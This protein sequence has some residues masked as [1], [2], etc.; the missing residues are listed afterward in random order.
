MVKK[1]IASFLG[2]TPETL[3]R[4][5]ADFAREGVIGL[6]GGREIVLL[7]T[8]ELEARAAGLTR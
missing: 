5:L 8:P 6:A 2:T 1:D 7:D 4:R 3:S